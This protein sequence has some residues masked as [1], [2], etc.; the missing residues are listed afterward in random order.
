VPLCAH[1]SEEEG[2]RD[3][4]RIGRMTERDLDIHL[5]SSAYDMH[6]SSSSYGMTGERFV[7]NRE[8]SCWEHKRQ[9]KVHNLYVSSSSYGMT[10][11][12]DL[13]FNREGRM[14]GTQKQKTVQDTQ[15]SGAGFKV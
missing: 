14:L 6:V 13:F 7:F 4:Y 5:S 9:C 2:T 12:R 3:A 1:C 11:E 10:G 15:S 8:E